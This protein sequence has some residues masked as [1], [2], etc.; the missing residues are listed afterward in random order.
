L[1]SLSD[2]LTGFKRG[3]STTAPARAGLSWATEAVKPVNK[4]NAQA[5]DSFALACGIAPRNAGQQKSK[6]KNKNKKERYIVYGKTIE[7]TQSA[8]DYYNKMGVKITRVGSGTTGSGT[9]NGSTGSPTNP[10]YPTITNE[11]Y[12]TRTKGEFEHDLDQYGYDPLYGQRD[13]QSDVDIWTH[14]KEVIHPKH[15]EQQ[16]YIDIKDEALFSGIKGIYETR[17]SKS[18]IEGKVDTHG[19]GFDPIG[20]LTKSITSI[21]I[22]AGLAYVGFKFVL[23]KVMKK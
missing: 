19:H 15:K 9:T 13:Y 4:T 1:P 20:D 5:F 11:N 6:P 18:D 16:E 12:I 23:P 2:V 14:I 8:V 3:T 22:I 10:T 17:R 7:L 21:L